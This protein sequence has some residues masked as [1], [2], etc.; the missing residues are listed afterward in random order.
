M[1]IIGL[2]GGIAAGK[3]TVSARWAEHGAVVVD[4]DQLARQAV[5]PGSPGLAQ[6]AER[7]G[8]GVL[9]ADGSLDRPALGAIVFADP[10]ARRALEGITHPEVWRLAQRAFDAA[11]AGDP[12]AVV[13]YDVPLL[14]EAAGS[15]PIRFD[16]VV[17][18]DAPAAQRIER[19]V[20]HRGMDRAEA[21][22]R[23]ASQASDA[24][25]LAL[26]DH[27]V[28]ATG[29]LDDTIRS[30]DEVWARVSG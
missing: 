11:E 19:L 29:S 27:V 12:D 14:A 9:A 21:E 22:R 4:A 24:D 1:R 28:D 15:R 25:R 13:V 30:A 10:D 3:S 20:E 5:A 7:F 23:V 8:P 2:T 16:A 17:V 18:V 6:V 26:A